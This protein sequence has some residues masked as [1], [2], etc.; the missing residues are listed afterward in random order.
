M[1]IVEIISGSTSSTKQFI[2]ADGEKWEARDSNG[3]I[4]AQYFSFG[5]TLGGLNYMF[6]RDHLASIREMTDSSDNV[7]AQYGYDLY[8]RVTKLQ[9]TLNSDFEFADY[10]FHARSG[11][12]LATHRAYNSNLGRWLSRDPIEEDGGNNLYAYVNGMPTSQIDPS[13]L[14]GFA[15]PLEVGIV[16]A[17]GLMIIGAYQRFVNDY[18]PSSPWVNPMANWRP[19]DPKSPEGQALDAA[20]RAGAKGSKPFCDS[21]QAAYD[22][23]RAAG[24]SDLA[25]KIKKIQKCMGCRHRG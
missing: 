13:G 5:Q 23:A 12:N 1:K 21:L 16:V 8:G 15:I 10:Y 24:N 2:W 9:G 4:Q 3:N 18:G 11:L 6:T 14:Q 20:S 25:G 22:A 19:S 17:G 7:Q